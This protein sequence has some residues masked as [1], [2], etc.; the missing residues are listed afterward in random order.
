MRNVS[1][2]IALFMITSLGTAYT[3]QRSID[4]QIDIEAPV[5]EVWKKWT[6]AKEAQTFLAPECR[7][8][9][10]P[11][12]LFEAHWFPQNP[13]GQKGAE[14]VHFLAIQENKML[15]F[16]WDA[17][18]SHPEIRKQRTFVV[19]HFESIRETLTRV[20]LTHTGW[21]TGKDWDEVYNNLIVAWGEQVLPFLK[22]S[23]EVGPID[24]KNRPSK[25]NLVIAKHSL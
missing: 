16:T 5:S 23:L 20:H 13:T 19:I 7:I 10:Y 3:Q 21:G 2:L 8:N 15:S 1:P 9:F 24:W 18:W 25:K 14:N 17:P 6:S 22:Y 11:M 12:G 4:L